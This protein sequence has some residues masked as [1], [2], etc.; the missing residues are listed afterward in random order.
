MDI[1]LLKE[2]KIS[3]TKGLKEV[4]PTSRTHHKVKRTRAGGKI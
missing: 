3:L 2:Q 4:F 1:K